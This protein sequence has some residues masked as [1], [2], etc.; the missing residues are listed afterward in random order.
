VSVGL[1]LFRLAGYVHRD[2]SGGNCLRGLDGRGRISDLEFAQ[3]YDRSS[4]HD[5]IAVGHFG[6]R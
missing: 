2:V 5:P 4:Q 6:L 3:R 1:N